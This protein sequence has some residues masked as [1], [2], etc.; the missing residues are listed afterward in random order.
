MAKVHAEPAPVR[1][2]GFLV[3]ADKPALSADYWAVAPA[4]HGWR[5]ELG[6]FSEPDNL[7]ALVGSGA[8]QSVS[9]GRTGRRAFVRIEDGRLLAA[10]YLSPDPVLVSRQWAVGLLGESGLTASVVLAGRPGSDRP[11]GGAIVCSCNSVGINTITDA[12]TRHSCST[13]D[14]VGAHTRAG[15]NCGSCR[16]EIRGII[17]AQLRARETANVAQ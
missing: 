14:A 3:A 5:V 8:V 7:S 6:F 9:D 4:P 15:T 1:L 16:A 17:D 11:D 10:L 12:I 13:V 2:Y